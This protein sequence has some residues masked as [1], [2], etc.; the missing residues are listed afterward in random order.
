THGVF[1]SLSANLA[2]FIGF[3]LAR[4]PQPTERLQANIF[5]PSDFSPAPSLRLFRT[6]VT[7]DDLTS[8]VSRYLGEERTERAFATF[9]KSRDMVLE[10]HREADPHLMRYSEQ[11]LASAIGAASSRLV[12]S[13]LVKRRDAVTKGALKL[14][15]DASA[16]IQYNRDLLQT[17][18]DQVRQ[19]IA[20]FDRELR[21][22]CWN[23]QF[24]ELLQLPVDFGQV[25]TPLN[26]ILHYNAD[27]GALGP[28]D[29]DALVAE[30]IDRFVARMETVQEKLHTNGTVLEV[31]TAPMPDGGI[32]MTYAD[33]TEQVAAA[34]AL[35]RSRA[36]LEQRVRERTEELTRLNSELG[37]AKAAAEAANIGKTR[38]IAAAGHDILQPL[39]AARLY[40][41]SLVERHVESEDRELIDNV[42][43]SLEA[44]EEIIGAV[45]DISR[46][47]AGALKPEI[48]VFCL[49]D[50]LRQLRIEFAP[51]ARDKQLDFTVVS[52]TV[53]VKSDRRLLRRVLQNLVSNAIKYTPPSGRVLVGCRRKR[54]R[55]SIN[56]YDNGLGIPYSQQNLI[57]EEFR[58]LE[59]GAKAA[60]GLGLGLSIV[61]R[62]ARVLDHPLKLVSAPGHGTNFAID[63]ETAAVA[64]KRDSETPPRTLPAIRLT[65]QTVLCIDNERK[66]LEGMAALLG[67]WGCTVVKAAGLREAMRELER[68]G[69]IPDVALVDYHLDDD[70]GINVVRRLRQ[71]YGE[72]LPAVLITA[73]RSPTVRSEARADDVTVLNK[74]LKPAALRAVLAQWRV[75]RSA[76]E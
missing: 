11:L 31:R 18:L 73:D 51:L 60:R 68:N 19:G 12:L 46:L 32:V 43:A 49:D 47:D 59:A 10:P 17:A 24:R 35:E 52:S 40:T 55:V 9:A 38:F 22:I 39:N 65:G 29:P 56:V 34:D 16:A 5:V 20:V 7:V 2:A 69:I 41:T 33:I 6:S 66:I 4:A 36:T 57:F 72:A 25:G 54:G 21:L 15:D 58:R 61:E 76:A 3:S 1:W 63:I 28:G 74:P 50:I 42:D 23:R 26:T 14:L 48:K 27:R 30:R 53:S 64:A 75:Q 62:V 45:L 8:T 37:R 13:L 71:R 70:T 44:V 67:G